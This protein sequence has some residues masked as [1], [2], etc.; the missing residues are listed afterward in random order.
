MLFP[1]RPQ[2][3]LWSISQSTRISTCQPHTHI[4]SSSLPTLQNTFLST[5]DKNTDFRQ[6]IPGTTAPPS[7]SSHH[8]SYEIFT[9]S[10]MQR[11]RPSLARTTMDA[12]K[13]SMYIQKGRDV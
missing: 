7:V 8:L 3:W 2:K 9:V 6:S 12:L 1:S 4:I 5:T 11:N 10:S 13:A